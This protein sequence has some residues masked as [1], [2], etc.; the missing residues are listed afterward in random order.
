MRPDIPPWRD[1]QWYSVEKCYRNLTPAYY[2]CWMLDQFGTIRPLFW[3][4]FGWNRLVSPTKM[5][6]TT[7]S[8]DAVIDFLL[9]LKII[10][11]KNIIW[12]CACM[13]LRVGMSL[14]RIIWSNCSVISNLLEFIVAKFAKWTY[15]RVYCRF[16]IQSNTLLLKLKSWHRRNF[17]TP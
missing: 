15:F 12:W 2:N 11:L 1:W 10:G 17:Y 6:L 16:T 4:K 5:I 13:L 8:F 9:T 3:I 14:R 7:V